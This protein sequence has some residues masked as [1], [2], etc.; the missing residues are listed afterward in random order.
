MKQDLRVAL[1]SAPWPIFN[2]PS[3]QLGT[4]KSFIKA[5]LPQIS[6][7]AFH[8]YLAC[9]ELIGFSAYHAI[10]QSSFASESV[11]ASLLFPD[12]LEK[13]TKVFYRNMAHRGSKHISFEKIVS[14]LKQGMEEFVNHTDWAKYGVIGFSV[15]LNQLTSS[16]WLANQ[17]KN[18][19]PNSKIV[20]GGSSC[21]GKL[22]R[23]LLNT[24]STID[25]VINGEGEIPLATLLNHLLGNAKN[26]DSQPG[27]LTKNS[28][29]EADNS[30]AQIKNLNTLPLPNFDDYFKELLILKP[31]NRFFPELP[32]EFSRGCWWQRCKFCNLN[33]QWENY[34][35]KNSERMAK[36]IDLLARRYNVLD[37][38]FMDN[39]L[40]KAKAPNF[41]DMLK[42]HKRDYNFFAEIRAAHNKDELMLMGK[43]GLKTVQVG[44]EAL[45]SSLLKRI[46]KG[47]TAF[48]NIAAMRNCYE[49][50]ITLLGN[51]II[52]F[53]SSTEAEVE[54]TLTNLD[55]VWPFLP[56]KTVSF[57]LGYGSPVYMNPEKFNISGIKPHRFFSDLF[58]SD[59]S[60]NL[61]PMVLQYRGDKL[62]Q[63][64]LWGKVETKVSEWQRN[65]EKLSNKMPLLSYRDGNDFMVIRQVMTDGSILHHRLNK[66]SRELYIMATTPCTIDELCNNAPKFSPDQVNAFVEQMAQKRLMFREGN[67]VISLAIKGN[68]HRLTKDLA[69]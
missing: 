4:L 13:C 1:I 66:V 56:L 23:S 49:A 30:K 60:K 58:P 32:V 15:C 33:L 64:K 41:F 39:A 19:S 47:T 12:N 63:R 45:S 51:L 27:I 9:A 26:I 14:K 29:P 34:R 37:F 10:S 16:L 25:Y 8:P 55:F 53:P 5:T 44:I 22:G 62:R 6:V 40:P 38:A 17:I 31:E 67:R 43:R 52:H 2:R 61:W 46:G 68:S 35:Q 69:V 42:E 3:I 36:E 57:W 7:Q 21:S 11:A 20:F 50:G 59:I 24:F 54:E 18:H 48:D 28:N 65:W